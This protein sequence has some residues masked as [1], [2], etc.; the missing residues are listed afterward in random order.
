VQYNGKRFVL[1]DWKRTAEWFYMHQNFFFFLICGSINAPFLLFLVVSSFPPSHHMKAKE[2]FVVSVP[3]SPL[4][5]ICLLSTVQIAEPMVSRV[6]K[7]SL[8]LVARVLSMVHSLRSSDKMH[9]TLW[10][11]GRSKPVA[12]LQTRISFIF[13]FFWKD[14]QI[15]M[16]TASALY[17]RKGMIMMMDRFTRQHE[18]EG[19]RGWSFSTSQ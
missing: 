12:M 18:W 3:D 11:N 8:F 13:I 17:L 5:E 4:L 7:M 1:R 14:F 10:T 19:G 15:F 6:V 16:S 2:F 9:G